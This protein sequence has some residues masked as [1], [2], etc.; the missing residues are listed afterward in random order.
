MNHHRATLIG[1]FAALLI[2]LTGCQSLRKRQDFDA[3][4]QTAPIHI[5]E[6]DK[7]VAAKTKKVAG[8]TLSFIGRSLAYVATEM[9]ED[10]GDDDED[11]RW[12]YRSARGR[13]TEYR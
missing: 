9:L 1:I 11:Q 2:V 13:N 3:L 6:P 4:T 7:P 8:G 12:D 10:W 5:P